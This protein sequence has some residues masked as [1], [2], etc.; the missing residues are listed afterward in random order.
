MSF[1]PGET[2]RIIVTRARARVVRDWRSR[3]KDWSTW[4]IGIALGWETLSAIWGEYIPPD[5][6]ALVTK[7]A[8]T[9]AAI[10]KFI[11]QGHVPGI[12]ADRE[13]GKP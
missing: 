9:F 2:T 1:N 6:R 13:G 5:I 10:G 3:L 12:P 8:L 7:T 11:H 4:G